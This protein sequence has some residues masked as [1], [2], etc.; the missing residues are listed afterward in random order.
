MAKSACPNPECKGHSF[1]AVEANIKG[2]DFPYIFIQC[3][4]CGTVVGTQ[5]AH[6]VGEILKEMADK[7][8]IGPLH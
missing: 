8:G 1:E 5:E 2:V 7:L 4:S 3:S 6:Y